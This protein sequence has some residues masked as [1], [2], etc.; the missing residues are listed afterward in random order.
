[1][2]TAVLG[3]TD[4]GTGSAAACDAVKGRW[5]YDVDPATGKPTKVILCPA[6][7][8]KVQADPA[9]SVNVVQGCTT[10]TVPH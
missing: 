9:G 7:C 5:Y 10:Q 1:V 8:S 2:P 6:T 3:A 4:V